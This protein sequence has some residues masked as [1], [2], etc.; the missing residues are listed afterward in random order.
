[1]LNCESRLENLPSVKE[2]MDSISVAEVQKVLQD[3]ASQLWSENQKF[4][5]D[6]IGFTT[7]S[8]EE[9]ELQVK[10]NGRTSRGKVKKK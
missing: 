10:E 3:R 7:L 8:K 6:E 2:D 9:V 4:V 1:M 5:S